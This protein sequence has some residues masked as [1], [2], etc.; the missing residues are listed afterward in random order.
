MGSPCLLRGF[1]YLALQFHN[2]EVKPC[3]VDEKKRYELL[4]ESVR[5]VGI[6]LLVFGPLETLLRSGNVRTIDWLIAFV[7][8]VFG[9]ILIAVGVSMGGE[10]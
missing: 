6:L 9:F 10:T 3:S 7:L 4:G 8:A 2:A 1:E 5:E